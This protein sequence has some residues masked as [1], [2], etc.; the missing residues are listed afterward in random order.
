MQQRTK[1]ILQVSGITIGGFALI[2]ITS[3]VS[4]SQSSSALPSTMRMSKEGRLKLTKSEGYRDF[5]YDDA[6]GELLYSYEEAIGYPT[7]GIGHLIKSQEN[8]DRF[9]RYLGDGDRMTR[10]EVADLLT[11]DLPKYEKPIQEK[12]TRPIT[13]AMFDSLTSL[14]FNIGPGGGALK[15]A[16]N[17]INEGKWEEASEAIRKGPTYSKGRQ[18]SGLVKR[19]NE[20]ADW[21]LAG[22]KPSRAKAIGTKPI[23]I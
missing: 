7:I 16:I 9:R 3:A 5:V 22:G 1:D 2:G 18:L 20:E 23:Q 10:E 8:K 19:R 11:E 6:N 4:A 14:A 15:K 12:V 21:F 13:Q 17:A